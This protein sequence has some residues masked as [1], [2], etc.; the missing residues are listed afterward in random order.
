MKYMLLKR[1]YHGVFAPSSGPRTPRHDPGPRPAEI[2]VAVYLARLSPAPVA[3]SGTGDDG[4]NPQLR[5]NRD[6][7][8]ST[9]SE[10][11]EEALAQPSGRQPVDPRHREIARL[12]K[13]KERLTGELDKARKVIEVQG[14]LSALLEQFATDSE[15]DERGE[16]R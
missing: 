5:P 16:T 14:K 1:G 6:P 7:S 15:Q 3:T 12:K 8:V 4:W 13:D 10:G 9:F 11:A 2:P